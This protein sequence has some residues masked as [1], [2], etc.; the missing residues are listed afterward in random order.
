MSAWSDRLKQ[1]WS[2]LFSEARKGEELSY[3]Q[4]S[5]LGDSL[6]DLCIRLKIMDAHPEMEIEELHQQAIKYVNPV[7]ER[8]FLEEIYVGLTDEEKRMVGKI[9]RNV[10]R[11]PSYIHLQDFQGAR[12]L[13]ALLAYLF[14]IEDFERLQSFVDRFEYLVEEEKLPKTDKRKEDI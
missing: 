12:A 8:L 3:N 2:L 7:T 6:L 10:S 13:E 9:K 11:F 1:L 4:L 5:Y 14:I